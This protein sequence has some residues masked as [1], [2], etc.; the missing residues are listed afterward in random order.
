ML[1]D[2]AYKLHFHIPSQKE[3]P[4]PATATITFQLA[5]GS[6]PLQLDFKEQTDHILS[7]VVNKRKVVVDH[8]Q[9]HL[10]LPARY[11]K[12]GRNQVDIRFIAGDLSLNRNDDYLYTLLV[13]DRARTVFPVF[14]QPNLKATFTLSLT[15]PG[16]WQAL[17]NGP[18]LDTVPG[19]GTRTYHFAASDTI[20]T[21]L[22]AFAAGK[23][24]RV[25]RELAGRPMQL[26]HRETDAKKLQLS[27][28]PIFQLH[29]GALA[30]ME[31]YTRIPYPFRKFDFVAIPDFQY[32]G[33]EHVGAID[34]KAA[35]LFLD[36][37]ATLDQQ[38]AR[39]SLTAHETAHMWFG[40]LVTMDWFNDVWM[41]E[42][43]ANFMAD[44]ITQVTLAHANFDLKFLVDHFPAAYGVD[45]TTGA[46]PIRQPL[47][48]LQ[49]AGSLYGNIIYHKA[50]IM[51]RQLES[52]M[53]AGPFQQGLQD[54]LARYAHGNATWPDLIGILDARS[55]ADLA[56][57]NQVWVNEPGRPLIDFSLET[58]AG[59]ISRLTVS[60][61]AEDGSDRLWPQH[62]E[63]TLVYPQGSKELAVVLDQR[64]VTL[65]A[66]AGEPAPTF[67]LFNSG[68]QG[69]GVFPVD[70]ALP[71]HLY[72]LPQPVARASA[73]INLYENMLN[74]RGITPRLLLDTYRR[75]IGR[76][77][78][79][80][81]LKLLTGQLSDIYWKFLSPAE[82]RALAPTL[83][84]ELWEAQR[85]NP[86]PNAK[87][88]L[89]KTYQSIALTKEAQ[90][91]LYRI[92][93]KQQPPAGILFSEEDYTALA[94][95]LAV[96]DYAP[97]NQILERQ[98]A[99]IRNVDRRKRLQFLMPALSGD[100][101]RRGAFFASL[102]EASNREKEAWV[103]A[104]LIYLH[105]PLRSAASEK[106]LPESLDLLAEIQ[107]TG[108]IFFPYNW[109]QST[110]GFY[111][112]SSAANTVR[113]FLQAHPDY[114]PRL[115]AK[116]RQAADDLFRAEKL[117]ARPD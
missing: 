12:T 35:T 69:Y 60:Q 48:N 66:A 21:Y 94:L 26:L 14:D 114:N 46:N 41:K 23:F 80:L 64:Q 104:A 29:A 20:P 113:A 102:K 33:M 101:R 93:E 87:K 43:F 4:I 9:E 73:Y 71:S 95:A 18:V 111:Q 88:L 5:A 58:E 24:Q 16:D 31:D 49:E 63:I 11:L 44:K 81:N 84:K 106:Y 7:L 107:R 53:G 59:R 36:E 10:M 52:L 105:H 103:A 100:E 117:V 3:N 99:R 74:G 2:L 39:A 98:L 82:R 19:P 37:G 50:P 42:V 51:M 34:Y 28:D 116:I 13:P 92:W 97:E 85:Q 90:Y 32:G 86:A 79:E 78:E 17:A 77:P 25:S 15:L 83:E 89:L 109:L 96:R 115:Q 110:L 54:Y 56:A 47:E 6:G 1:R 30:F 72:A 112:T 76:E 57:W 108:D 67:I 8:R 68:G 70:K 75:G 65:A 91:T 27:L 55:P 22:F 45:R 40:D 62:F 38:I 61:Q